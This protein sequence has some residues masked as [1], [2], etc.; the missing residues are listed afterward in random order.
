MVGIQYYRGMA[1]AGEV[2]L[3]KREPRNPV[4]AAESHG[5]GTELTFSSMILTLFVWTM[6]LGSRS[7]IFQEL[8]RQSSRLTSYVYCGLKEIG[9]ANLPVG[10]WRH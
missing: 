9:V 8:L 1:T 7:G 2:V 10:Q 3:L 4:G 6:C 5:F